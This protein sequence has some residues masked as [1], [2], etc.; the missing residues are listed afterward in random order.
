MSEKPKQFDKNMLDI[1]DLSQVKH[2]I[3][4]NYQW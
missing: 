2:V 4:S 1:F 3:K